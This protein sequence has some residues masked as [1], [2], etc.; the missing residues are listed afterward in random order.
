MYSCWI[1]S[2]LISN[3][4]SSSELFTV[5][6]RGVRTTPCSFCCCCFCFCTYT[7]ISI[8]HHP[9]IHTWQIITI[10][11]RPFVI[12]WCAIRSCYICTTV[13]DA[14]RLTRFRFLVILF[15]AQSIN[16]RQSINQLIN[17]SV[18]GVLALL[19]LR[20]SKGCGSG[21]SH[22]LPISVIRI[23]RI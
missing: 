23:E 17:Q 15:R 13:L 18:M 4:S 22:D 11:Q 21:I 1:E 8:I 16:N 14:G 6:V 2:L 20:H 12:N 10:L 5:E 3:S 9:F 7:S 19:L